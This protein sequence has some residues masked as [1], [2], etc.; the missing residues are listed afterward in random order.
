LAQ[1]LYDTVA[2]VGSLCR[3]DMDAQ[4]ERRTDRLEEVATPLRRRAQS[5]VPATP[6]PVSQKGSRPPAAA[7]ADPDF[8]PQEKIRRTTSGQR[9]GLVAG[10]AM[11]A[12]ACLRPCWLSLTR[13]MAKPE[14]EDANATITSLATVEREP[15]AGPSFRQQIDRALDCPTIRADVLDVLA[16]AP[17]EFSAAAEEQGFYRL[18]R[19]AAA[20]A[21]RDEAADSQAEEDFRKAV[22]QLAVTGG[23]WPA[24]FKWRLRH[25]LLE[26][27]CQA[28]TV[29]AEAP[30]P[31]ET[32]IDF[33]YTSPRAR[34]SGATH[35]A[36]LGLGEMTGIPLFKA[37]ADVYR[38]EGPSV[39]LSSASITQSRDCFAFRGANSSLALRLA[40]DG[41]G[42]SARQ[43]VIEQPARWAAL[44]PRSAPRRFAVFGLPANTGRATTAKVG[45][46]PYTEFL[47]SFEYA[48]AGPAAQAFELPS[49]MVLSGLLLVFSGPEW[50]ESY[51]CLYRVKVFEESGTVCSGRRIAA[52]L[53][54]L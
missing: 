22:L 7:R 35:Q 15:E 24:D 28:K 41:L 23:G 49:T 26:G 18:P 39:V 12:F 37:R 17:Y 29:C 27:R 46:G 11:L 31:I 30:K 2:E 1:G 42:V 6:Q 10:V 20:A 19:L 51:I 43:L 33:S 16:G 40:P 38:S 9:F 53:P 13:G 25:I 44:R 34:S 47:G 32:E 54:R 8:P 36:L 3:R 48:A 50:G 5:P 52:V 45:E 21:T 14:A 4:A